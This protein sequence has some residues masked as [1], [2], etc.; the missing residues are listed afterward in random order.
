[1]ESRNE[2]TERNA[3]L[4]RGAFGQC[5]SSCEHA[6]SRYL[7]DTGVGLE[8]AVARELIPAIAVLR[9]AVE[10]LDRG[11][12]RRQLALT[13]VARTCRRAASECRRSGLDDRLLPCVA[14]C[15]E[16]ADLARA[17]LEPAS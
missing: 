13:L 17:G 3:S 7:A 4:L 5:A 15:E 12:P 10:Y 1:M 16:V 2:I 6:L 14:R 8:H 9:T 11:D